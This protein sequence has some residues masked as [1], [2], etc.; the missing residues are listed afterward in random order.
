[1]AEDI[2]SEPSHS[3]IPV[4]PSLDDP[5]SGPKAPRGLV[6]DGGTV[7]ITVYSIVLGLVGG[8]SHRPSPRS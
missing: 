3:P 1:M 8:S 7:R 6:I 5:T 2:P 4:A